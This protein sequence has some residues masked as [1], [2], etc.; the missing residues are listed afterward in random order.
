MGCA[1]TST[2]TPVAISARWSSADL[3]RLQ[4]GAAGVSRLITGLR[5]VRASSV[6]VAAPASA[7]ALVLAPVPGAAVP[8]GVGQ[9]V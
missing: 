3:A 1:K 4:R 7:P 8:P 2:V 9:P 5:Q 6:P